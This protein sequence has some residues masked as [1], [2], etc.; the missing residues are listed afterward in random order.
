M[1]TALTPVQ[2]LSISQLPYL[3][4][5]QIKWLNCIEKPVQ[6]GNLQ[7]ALT[8]Q[9]SSTNNAFTQSG[10][11]QSAPREGGAVVVLKGNFKT[12]YNGLWLY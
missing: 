2:G 1:Y 7:I 3:G 5:S 12:K 10:G 8:V 9:K 4:L 11:F 6:T